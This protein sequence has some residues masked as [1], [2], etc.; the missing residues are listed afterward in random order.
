MKRRINEL[1]AKHNCL[2]QGRVS[3]LFGCIDIVGKDGNL[4]KKQF[5]DPNS[6]LINKFCARLIENGVYMWVRAPVFHCA[7]PLIITEEQLNDGFDK[8][9]DAFKILDF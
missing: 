5:H 2:R 8:I 1:I 4:I 6:D 3:G 9:D 7:P